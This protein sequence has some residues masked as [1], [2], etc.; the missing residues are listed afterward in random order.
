MFPIMIMSLA[1][2]LFLLKSSDPII[3]VTTWHWV[4]KICWLHSCS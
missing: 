3:A 4:V 1:S 2:V